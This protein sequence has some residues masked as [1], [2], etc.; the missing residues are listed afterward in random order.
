MSSVLAVL[1]GRSTGQKNGSMRRNQKPI[2]IGMKLQFDIYPRGPIGAGYYWTLSEIRTEGNKVLCT[3]E[4]CDTLDKAR[5]LVNSVKTGA[6]D[7]KIVEHPE[8]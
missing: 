2:L 4:T 7:A 6:H 5:A 1:A 3:S 8:A